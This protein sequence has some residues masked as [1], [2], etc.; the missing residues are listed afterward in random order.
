MK[1]AFSLIN[2]LSVVS[3]KCNVLLLDAGQISIRSSL[4]DKK[5]KR[6]GDLKRQQEISDEDLTSLAPF[7][8]DK[9]TVRLEAAQV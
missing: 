8:Y 2:F 5:S 1:G 9:Y 7:I 3:N 4:V 6:L